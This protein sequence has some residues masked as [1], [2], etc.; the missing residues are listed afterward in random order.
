MHNNSYLTFILVEEVFYF[1]NSS[2]SLL[3]LI[4]KLSDSL[5]YII[6]KNTK[7][8]QLK[9]NLLNKNILIISESILAFTFFKLYY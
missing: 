9:Q 5:L 6:K 1:L 4:F 7:K 2:E 8:K 3:K